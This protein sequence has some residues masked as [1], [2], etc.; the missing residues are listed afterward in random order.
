MPESRRV[1]HVSSAD[2]LG[3]AEAIALALHRAALDRGDDSWLA[4][5]TRHHDDARTLEIPNDAARPLRARV[6]RRVADALPTTLAPL[7]RA[8]RGRVGE[9]ARARAIAAGAEDFEFPATARL[10][11]LPPRPPALLHLHNLHGGYFDLRELPALTAR[12]PTVITLHDAWLLAGHCAHSFACE[13][14][15]TGCGSCPHLD[16]YPAI[17]VDGSAANWERKRDL[18]ARSRLS[19]GVP[20]E[21]LAARV[22]ASIVAPAV[23]EL[24]VIPHGVDLATFSPAVDRAALRARHHLRGPVVLVPV[25]AFARPSWQDATLWAAV[26][27]ALP[28]TVT[29]VA[30]GSVPPG[31][32]LPPGVRST[33][34]LHDPREVADWFRMA[35]VYAHPTRADTFATQILESLACGTPVVATAVGGVPEQVREWDGLDGGG[36]VVAAGD[37]AAFTTALRARLEADD[38]EAS[39]LRRAAAADA[40]SRFD[41]RRMISAYSAW[42]DAVID[43][44]RGQ[45]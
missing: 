4:V 14:W 37:A 44:A 40:Q 21:W 28:A 30:L 29:V 31:V 7:A 32:L 33:G 34:A 11:E 13:R 23:R 3:G 20:C 36:H 22:R 38:A 1:L 24:R 26:H 12:V 2:R 8:L 19:V 41:V 9:P 27:R 5:G 42:W 16:I 6:A 45:G 25:A 15:R 10:L 35:D 18:L 43:A 39:A 17:P